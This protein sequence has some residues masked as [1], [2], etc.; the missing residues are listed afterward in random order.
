MKK[1]RGLVVKLVIGS[2]SI[3]ALLGIIALLAGG[4]F[5]ETE[6]RILLTTV[7]A[8]VTSIAVLCY[9]AAADK[10]FQIV[11][12]IGGISVLVP[13][14][15]ALWLTWF[16]EGTADVVWRT[17]SIGVT[18]SASLAQACLLLA[19]A[20][21][22]RPVV[23][24]MLYA[25]LALI[26]VVAVLIIIPIA[27]DSEMG[28]T[29]MRFFGI[30]AILDVLGTVTVAAVQKFVPDQREEAPE[31]FLDAA[32]ESRIADAARERGVSKAQLISDA[33]DS[34]LSPKP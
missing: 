22:A 21:D 32:L 8:G 7:I 34:L 25:T 18:V 16:G 9:L 19:V 14:T 29:Y 31:P 4:S 20:Y 13:L 33:L 6:G 17:F 1:L 30:S 23:R 28:G 11:G 2:F 12:L 24:R 27:G 10:P 15:L 26:G 5:G 3:A